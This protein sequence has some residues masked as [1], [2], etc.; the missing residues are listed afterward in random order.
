MIFIIFLIFITCLFWH[1]F[2]YNIF[3]L[4]PLF[5]KACQQILLPVNA[6]LTE[7]ELKQNNEIDVKNPIARPRVPYEIL[8]A[9]GG[10]SA[11]SPTSFVETYDTRCAK[12]LQSNII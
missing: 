11:G 5:S 8:F 9:I 2:L 12:F 4:N 3:N 6:Y 7:Q 1:F 10:W